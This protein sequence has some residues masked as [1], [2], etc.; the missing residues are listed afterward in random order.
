MGVTDDSGGRT[1]TRG[2]WP[3]TTTLEIGRTVDED[4]AAAKN[5]IRNSVR[6][7]DG[8]WVPA[9]S[10]SKPAWNERAGEGGVDLL[11]RASGTIIWRCTVQSWGL[12]KAAGSDRSH[13]PGTWWVC[14]RQQVSPGGMGGSSATRKA[15]PASV[16]SCRGH[17]KR[18]RIGGGREVGQ[19]LGSGWESTA[20]RVGEGPGSLGDTVR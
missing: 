2:R 12:G 19:L 15:A 4:N 20:A 8:D 7:C 18:R 11:C 3:G 16:R 10:R 5:H 6:K 17:S 1:L 14:L 9:V 13:S